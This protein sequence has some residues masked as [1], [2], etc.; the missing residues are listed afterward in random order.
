MIATKL[1]SLTKVIVMR[2]WKH[3]RPTNKMDDNSN[4]LLKGDEHEA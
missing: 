2:I 4:A 1:Q 3:D